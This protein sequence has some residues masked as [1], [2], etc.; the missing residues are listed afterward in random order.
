MARERDQA[1]LDQSLLL[2]RL[3]AIESART[4]Q[5][6][7]SSNLFMRFP[8]FPSPVESQVFKGNLS[9]F[10]FY[11]SASV[12]TAFRIS[13]SASPSSL[14]HAKFFRLKRKLFFTT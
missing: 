14:R 7:L 8:H 4:Q 10:L 11:L 5:S 2:E 3:K 6:A 9:L 13:P 1:L 12:A